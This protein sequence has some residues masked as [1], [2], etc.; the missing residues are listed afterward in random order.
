[1]PFSESLHKVGTKESADTSRLVLLLV[2]GRYTSLETLLQQN[3]Y[4]VIGPSTPDHGVA[5]CLHNRV[6]AALIDEEFLADADTWSLA[7]SLK[8]VSPSTSI[9]LLVR[10]SAAKGYPLRGVDYIVNDRESE[11]VLNALKKCVP[12]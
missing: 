10:G 11:Q 1:M 3:G 2:G 5:V 8:A 9:V 6:V 12:A 7:E 4:K